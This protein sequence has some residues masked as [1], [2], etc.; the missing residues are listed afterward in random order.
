MPSFWVAYLLIL[1]FAVKL[2]L[3]PVAGQG[4]WKHLILPSVTLG[5]AACASMM[6]LTRSEMLE[7]LGQDYIRTAFAKGLSTR[8]VVLRHAFK[9]AV[10]PVVSYLGPA[11]AGILTGSLVVEQIF[12]IP[13]LGAHFI[14]SATQRDLTLAMGLVLLYTALL[15]TM[16]LLVDIAYTLL[17]PRVKLT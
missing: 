3:L 4:S 13:G 17:D 12:A 9:G 5:L 10:I 2:Q 6:R 8:T 16:N 14:Q 1:L 11:I 15:Y 7:V